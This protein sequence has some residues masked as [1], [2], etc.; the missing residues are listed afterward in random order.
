MHQRE[1]VLK[2]VLRIKI[3]ARLKREMSTLN[4]VPYLVI[5]RVE[6]TGDGPNWHL[7]FCVGNTPTAYAKAWERIRAQFEAAYNISDG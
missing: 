5:E 7:S 4:G 2:D 6:P 3:A 1:T